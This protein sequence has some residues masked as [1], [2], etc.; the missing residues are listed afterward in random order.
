MSADP[1][2]VIR[3][4]ERAATPDKPSEDRIF[5]T[6]N[7]VIVLDGA[8]QAIK[9]ERDGGWMAEQLGRR[10]ADGL[11]AEPD[12]NL[13]KLLEASITDMVDTYELVPGESPSATSSI[14]RLSDRRLDVM[15]LCDS[16]VIVQTVDG[17]I[18]QIRDDRLDEIA[19]SIPRPPGHRDMTDPRWIE[20][21]ESFEAHRNQPGG[22]WVAS[23]TPEA[24]RHTIERSFEVDQVGTVLA[25][26]DGLSIGVDQYGIPATWSDAI[27][28]AASDPLALIDAVHQAEE[29]D[30]ER[31][32]WRRS[33]VY[34]DKSLAVVSTT[35]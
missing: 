29:S 5:Q 30:T 26:T 2:L 6:P 13:P 8:S 34:D 25:M 23:A 21:V 10:L 14:V 22:F 3:T 20:V 18:H 33:K 7:A 15:V 4:A 19:D 31:T 12:C 16:P 24:A 1:A 28:L 9:L 32:R 27:A 17:E 35:E 11:L